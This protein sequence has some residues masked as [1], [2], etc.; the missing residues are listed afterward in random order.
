MNRPKLDLIASLYLGFVLLCGTVYTF[1]GLTPSSYGVILNLIGVPEDGP[2][3]GTAR[4]IR[5]DEFAGDTAFLQIAIRNGFKVVN[6]TSF[7]REDLRA[8]AP[9]P[10]KDWSLVFKPQQWAFLAVSPATAFS[11]YY[12]LIMC[13]FLIGYFLLFRQMEIDSF[14]SASGTVILY[15]SGFTQFWW[16]SFGSLLAGFPWI[17]THPVHAVALVGESPAIQLGYAST[18]VLLHLS[19]PARGICLYRVGSHGSGSALAIPLA[20]YPRSRSDWRGRYRRRVLLL[21]P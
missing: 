5:S 21:L 7:Y 13:G 20:R 14:A 18:D 16:T 15:F 4:S 10:L 17:L 11:F 3:F 9:L 8:S 2:I 1:F 12:A 19:G 6:E